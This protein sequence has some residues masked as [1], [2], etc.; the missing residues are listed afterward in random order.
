MN[1]QI[2]IILGVVILALALASYF[3]LLA[4][5]GAGLRVN[6]ITADRVISND[7]DIASAK[8]IIDTTF[9]GSGGAIWGTIGTTD[10]KDANRQAVATQ[11]D[12]KITAESVN[13]YATYIIENEGKVIKKY[14][15]T[16]TDYYPFS[17]PAGTVY[18]FGGFA[19]R[20]YIIE[21]SV[22]NKGFFSSK[23]VDFEGT[24]N[25][26]SHGEKISGT[27]SNYGADVTFRTSDGQ[28]VGDCAW[29]GSS[30]T[31]IGVPEVSGFAVVL[32]DSSSRWQ[33]TKEY[34]W[35]N[36]DNEKTRFNS[37][38]SGWMAAAFTP[39]FSEA[40]AELNKI[41]TAA[42]DLLRIDRQILTSGQ[43]QIKVGTKDAIKVNLRDSNIIW[44][45]PN[46]IFYV[47][48]S[49]VGAWIPVGKPQ[50][51]GTDCDDV[52]SG[53]SSILH[54]RVRNDGSARAT[55]RAT[56]MDGTCKVRQT[57]IG[58]L[59][60]NPGET[61]VID[62]RIDQGSY[63]LKELET[64]TV[65][66]YDANKAEN[67]DTASFTCQLLKAQECVDIGAYKG[68]T[69]TNCISVCNNEGFWEQ[70]HCCEDDEELKVDA[71]IEKW[72]GWHCEAKDEE[73]D[74]ECFEACCEYHGYTAF[75]YV[76]GLRCEAECLFYDYIWYFIAGGGLFIL[77]L[78][79]KIRKLF[80][81]TQIAMRG[82]R[83]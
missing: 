41:N 64:C 55:F 75:D 71:S 7:A 16:G 50:I 83:R 39:S 15:R 65:K 31:G 27:I 52:L 21:E 17:K 20:F 53:K 38:M 13:E 44:S 9:D 28:Y 2:I 57:S 43:S 48:A 76:G 80:S 63:N 23:N 62:I 78:I 19:A 69:R 29:G 81:P 14:R 40:D 10:F 74:K 6:A 70:V 54:V 5:G 11:Y 36:Y 79:F 51:L 72:D 1:K 22:G 34:E 4:I 37:A 67:Y 77:Y 26:E 18:T 3:D 60:F 46:V 33:V 47:K 56:I 58:E 25:V 30:V 42:D 32:P 73:D 24:I 66:V 68:D 49:W 8:F 12:L 59:T 61:R 35:R 45:R 82:V